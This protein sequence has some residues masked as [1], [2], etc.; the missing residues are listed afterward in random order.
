MSPACN[1]GSPRE[2]EEEALEQ[3]LAFS[4]HDQG[5]DSSAE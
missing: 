5:L 4:E 3:P 2:D 1:A